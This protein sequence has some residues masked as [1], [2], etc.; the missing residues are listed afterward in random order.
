MWVRVGSEV[1][2]RKAL[3][4]DHLVSVPVLT[5]FP[6][7]ILNVTRCFMLNSLAPHVVVIVTF[8]T[9]TS[10]F[11]LQYEKIRPITVIVKKMYNSIFP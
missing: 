3:P 7:Y 10:H 8:P 6:G 4:F 5:L 1:G 2:V 9:V 11:P